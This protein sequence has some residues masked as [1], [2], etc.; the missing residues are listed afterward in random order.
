[1]DP[2]LK[3]RV[4]SLLEQ[5]EQAVDESVNGLL[6][7]GDFRQF[8]CQFVEATHL[9]MQQCEKLEGERNASA[10][11]LL[12]TSHLTARQPINPLTT[13]ATW[14]GPVS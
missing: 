7:R 6:D 4:N 8:L 14:D 9:L 2:G 10:S 12:R 5:A 11:R 1:M 13:S 3:N